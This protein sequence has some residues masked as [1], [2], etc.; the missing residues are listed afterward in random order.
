M[1]GNRSAYPEI[2]RK[3]SRR[4]YVLL[5]YLPTSRLNHITNDA[6]RRRTLANLFHACL[7]YIT[8]P[9]RDAGI[10]GLPMASGDGQIRRCHPIVLVTC[11]KTG[12]CPTCDVVHGKLGDGI[13]A[14]LRHLDNILDALDTLDQGGTVYAKACTAAGIK[15][16]VHPFWE[17]LP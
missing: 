3:T 8:A 2:R 1:F 13:A 14:H 7:S 9:L 12:E 4:A 17:K 11:V 10:S 16:V 15:P 6:S 5:A